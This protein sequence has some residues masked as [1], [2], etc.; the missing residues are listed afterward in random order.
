MAK[1]LVVEWT[2]ASVRLVLAQ[3]Q[4]RRLLL[5]S[6]RSEPIGAS[7]EVGAALRRLAQALGGAP[8]EVIGVIAREHVLTRVVKFPSTQTAELAQ[9]V[10]LYA[11]AQLPYPRE[12][13]VV[14]FHVLG[15]EGGFST[16]AV[17][18]CQREVVDRA[19]SLLQEAGLSPALLTVSPW[20]VLEWYRQAAPGAASPEP[21]L[22]INM[23]D[24]RTDLVLIGRGRIL[25]SRSVGQGVL[26]WPSTAEVVELLAAEVERSRAAVRKELTDVEVRSVVLTGA[27]AAPECS[28]LLAERL[29]LPVTAV[30]ARRPFR[31]GT[32]AGPLPISMVVAGGLAC[33]EL[34]G[35]L[36]LNPAELRAQ[37]HHREQVRDLRLVGALVAGVLALAVGAL[38]VRA[39]RHG[40]V[41][42]QMAQVIRQAEPEAKRVKER[43]RA[44]Q[45]AA[46][47]LQSRRQLAATLAGVLATTPG[48]VSLEAVNFE[49]SRREVVVRGSTET[50]QQV[51]DYVAQ[52]QAVEGVAEVRL[53]HSTRRRTPSGSRT[54]FELVLQQERT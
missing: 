52:L 25:S 13:M 44:V 31:Q 19:L 24:A 12:Q 15:Q 7:G 8:T 2:R 51:L 38:A 6:L 33:S 48:P 29:G 47:V 50:T 32:Q 16:V 36:N 23:D 22:V 10:E 45:V 41:A 49:R 26:D 35:A 1:R 46:G 18:A 5:Q 53:K 40:R 21:V 27:S 28:G 37:V 14:D 3:R 54:D 34:R 17:V 30:D 9:M 43:A 20:G 39:A 42:K 4:G 11:K